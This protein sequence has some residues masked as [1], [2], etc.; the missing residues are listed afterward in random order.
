MKRWLLA[1]FILFIIG[2]SIIGFTQTSTKLQIKSP[3]TPTISV[4]S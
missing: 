4:Q 3:N 1:F 2:F